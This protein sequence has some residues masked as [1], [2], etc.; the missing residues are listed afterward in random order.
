MKLALLLCALLAGSAHADF[1]DGRV[2]DQNGVGI[3]NVDLDVKN[4]GSGGTPNILN[5]GSDALG[6]F[7]VTVPNG[8]YRVTLKP[9]QP[10]AS[11]ALLSE[12][13]SV[14]IVGT[15]NFGTITLPT[16]AV[17]SGHV[18]NSIGAP[19]VGVNIDVI[20]PAGDNP[21]LLYDQTDAAGNFLLTAPP[22][23]IQVRFDP[24]T[25]VG[26]T[27]APAEYAIH[28]STSYAF[29][30]LQLVPGYV[31][32]GIV[33]NPSGT[34]IVDADADVY[35]VNTGA[36]LFTPGDTSSGTGFVDFVVP[37]GSWDVD[38][39][40][41]TG[42]AL[43]TKRFNALSV[44]ANTSLGI[45]TLPTGI[46][47]S[48]HV[49]N[50]SGVPMPGANVDLRDA[51]SGLSIGLS[52]D[53]TN[54][55]GNYS[56]YV[57]AGTYDVYLKPPGGQ[58]LAV[59]VRRGISVFG[60]TVVN[61]LLGPAYSA[62]CFGDGS[63]SACPCGNASAPGASAGC[64]SSLGYGGRLLAEGPACVTADNMHLVGHDM[65]NAPA[66]YFQGSLQQS[67]GA[68]SSFGD[69]LLCAG[70]TIVRLGV[71]FN[72]N[73][74][75]LHPASGG[76]PISSAGGV[77]GGATHTYQAW[78]RD[79]VAFCTASNFNLTNGLQVVWAP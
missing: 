56:V 14:T 53:G 78:Y 61:G 26:Q 49:S 38:V 51:A 58:N 15:A 13:A 3:P 20:D 21:T 9:P 46:V 10:P 69:G 72:V 23:A 62:F 45:V 7:H 34:A 73:G 12:I 24:S 2:V 37:A 77:L 59:D 70:G 43:A 32:S 52:N 60:P 75:S 6:F 39:G 41:P 67:G 40:P 79:A 1:L 16:G 47:L 25:V 63:G 18:V 64:A 48:G 8:T 29:G 55:A 19:V 54:A 71:Q 5:D 66:L 11:T 22:G 68:G 30:T 35:D 17:L 50:C 31:I 27:L 28:A 65:G 36:K 44:G 33:R 42:L 74:S 57:A 76:L 4:L